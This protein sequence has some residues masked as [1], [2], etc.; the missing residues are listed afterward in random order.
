[1]TT[2]VAAVACA[3]SSVP[4]WCSATTKAPTWEL[5]ATRVVFTIPHVTSG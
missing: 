5:P 1:M 3:C 2:D 4:T